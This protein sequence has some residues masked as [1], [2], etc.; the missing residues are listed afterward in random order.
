MDNKTIGR[1]IRSFRNL[2]GLSQAEVAGKLKMDPGGY[3]R[4][5][6]GE[7]E[8]SVKR[9]SDLASVLDVSLEQLVSLEPITVN[10]NHSSGTQVGN[11]YHVQFDQHVIPVAFVHELLERQEKQVAELRSLVEQVIELVKPDRKRK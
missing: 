5:E 3:S 10:V 2:R 11:G 6:S 7:S 1:R 4:L 9:L 8:V